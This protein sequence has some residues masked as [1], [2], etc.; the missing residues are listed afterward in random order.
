ME[1]LLQGMHGG[2][3]GWRTNVVG[4]LNNR[5]GIGGSRCEI[6]HRPRG[7]DTVNSEER[8]G[9]WH[10][11]GRA[12]SGWFASPKSWSFFGA[13]RASAITWIIFITRG[14]DFAIEFRWMTM[15]VMV[16]VMLSRVDT[17]QFLLHRFRGII[18]KITMRVAGKP[19]TNIAKRT[20]WFGHRWTRSWRITRVW[21]FDHDTNGSEIPHENVSLWQWPWND[22]ELRESNEIQ[23]SSHFFY[24]TSYFSS[25][26]TGC[27]LKL[28]SRATTASSF[29]SIIWNILTHHKNTRTFCRNSKT[30]ST[31]CVIRTLEYL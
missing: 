26:S 18:V 12:R 22:D 23:S 17:F 25:K 2:G 24:I 1:L 9:R 11:C 29:V 19:R 31:F 21:T 30:H 16:D 5:D 28:S 14:I 3:S 20:R 4:M 6:A 15:T 8:S 7:Q 13:Y 10:S 27:T